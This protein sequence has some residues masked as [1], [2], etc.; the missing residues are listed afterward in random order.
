MLNLKSFLQSEKVKTSVPGSSHDTYK[1]LHIFLGARAPL[2]L[3]HVK[4]ENKKKGK[5]F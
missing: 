5:S 1:P 2:E 3:A 4:K